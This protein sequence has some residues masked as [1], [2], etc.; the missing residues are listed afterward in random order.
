[1]KDNTEIRNGV[2]IEKNRVRKMLMR[3]IFTENANQK[4]KETG[5]S[6]MVTKLQKIIEE[7]VKCL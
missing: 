4:T 3:I 6:E 2:N 7:E 1:M 5:D